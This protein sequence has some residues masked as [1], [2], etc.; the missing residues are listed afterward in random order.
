MIRKVLTIEGVDHEAFKVAIWRDDEGGWLELGLLTFAM[1]DGR[2]GEIAGGGRLEADADVV[3][4]MEVLIA[5][6]GGD[7]GLRFT[8]AT[9]DERLERRFL[10]DAK[11][12][13]DEGGRKVDLV[14]GVY[15]GRF[16]AG[17]EVA[18][19]AEATAV[20]R[21]AAAMAETADQEARA[22]LERLLG[23]RSSELP[24]PNAVEAVAGGL[25]VAVLRM[26]A[27]S[28]ENPRHITGTNLADLLRESAAEVASD[29]ARAELE[30]RSARSS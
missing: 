23:A 25:I 10:R 12:S 15:A 6:Q 3:S 22:I 9:G 29:V 28:I 17:E 16:D 30:A 5:S 20:D 18:P 1:A 26:A 13:G 19:S 4:I 7:V 14:L 8:D 21:L 11:L 27:A 2:D 24:F